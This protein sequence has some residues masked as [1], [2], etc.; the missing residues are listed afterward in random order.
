MQQALHL[1]FGHEGEKFNFRGMPDGNCSSPRLASQKDINR[2]KHKGCDEKPI[3]QFAPPRRRVFGALKNIRRLR[4][5]LS[6]SRRG[7]F[8]QERFIGGV[9]KKLTRITACVRKRHPAI[10]QFR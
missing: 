10:R 3:R 6:I 1:A 5:E 2:Q 9:R 7:D 8:A 4:I